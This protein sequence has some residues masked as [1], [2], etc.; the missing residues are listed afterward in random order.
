MYPVLDITDND[1]AN[2]E[3]VWIDP[4]EVEFV[5]TGKSYP[6]LHKNGRKYKPVLT[7]EQLQRAWKQ[8]GFLTT[9]RSNTVNI[10]KV[11]SIDVKKA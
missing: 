2:K 10:N 6:I 7:I 8:F 3:I 9:D 1:S 5:S 11:H 4:R